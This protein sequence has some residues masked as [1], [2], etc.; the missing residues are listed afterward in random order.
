ML[1]SLASDILLQL[2]WKD[3]TQSWWAVVNITCFRNFFSKNLKNNLSV[4]LLTD[5]S[6]N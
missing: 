5:T 4:Y 6:L 3:T 1:I 2:I